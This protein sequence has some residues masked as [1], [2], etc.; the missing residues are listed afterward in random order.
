MKNIYFGTAV[1]LMGVGFIM[2]MF[3]NVVGLGLLFV[4]AAMIIN[5]DK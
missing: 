3:G 4:G 2:V 5:E 1:T